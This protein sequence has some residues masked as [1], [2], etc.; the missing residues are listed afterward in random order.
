MKKVTVF[1]PVYNEEGNLVELHS[2]LCKTIEGLP[3]Y[4]FDI[5]YVNDC[6]TDN[7]FS[8]LNKIAEQD[9][10]VRIINHE[11]QKGQAG[12][13][14]TGFRE[15]KGDIIIVLDADLQAEPEQIPSFLKE[16]EKGYD[17]VNGIRILRKA[18][19]FGIFNSQVY[20]IV[21]CFLFGLK[22]NDVS[23]SYLA[24]RKEFAR[25]LKLWGNDHRYIVPI[26]SKRGAK[27]SEVC[28]VHGRRKSGTSKYS[29]LKLIPVVVEL[30]SFYR[31]FKAG[32]YDI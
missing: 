7:T 9:S 19:S 26:L 27:I 3:E 17:A 5:A 21:Q 8:V 14:E 32:K 18:S 10:K 28:I 22:V 23:S 13:F 25:N 4:S 12:C 15:A 29:S 16:I 11:K 31:R 6:S 30:F 20:N 2:R 1:S 24:V